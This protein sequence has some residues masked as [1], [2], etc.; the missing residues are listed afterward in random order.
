[1]QILG[2]QQ[3]AGRLDHPFHRQK[4]NIP[5]MKSLQREERRSG[6][7]LLLAKSKDRFI[8]LFM[9]ALHCVRPDFWGQI[10]ISSHTKHACNIRWKLA[11][12]EYNA[13][14]GHFRKANHSRPS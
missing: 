6:L 1:M 3:P 9:R 4:A 14:D 8:S 5:H 7:P 11:C 10:S 2:A 13:G 12:Q